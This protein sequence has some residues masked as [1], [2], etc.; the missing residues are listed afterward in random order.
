MI[1][2]AS[3]VVKELIRPAEESLLGKPSGISSFY[4]Q[5]Q[6]K[7]SN[8]NTDQNL[9]QST[10]NQILQK[11]IAEQQQ[12]FNRF[13]ETLQH[14]NPE[15]Y[16][17]NDSKII[18]TENGPQLYKRIISYKALKDI[19]N[20]YTIQAKSTYYTN[21]NKEYKPNIINAPRTFKFNID[22]SDI[23]N[24][25]FFALDINL[26]SEI[27]HKNL[28]LKK[29]IDTLIKEYNNIEKKQQL[30]I[31]EQK[32]DTNEY[33][34][35]NPTIKK[36]TEETLKNDQGQEQNK[37]YKMYGIGGGTVLLLI[38]GVYLVLPQEK[39]EKIQKID[40][41]INE[42]QQEKNNIDGMSPQGQ[43]LKQQE[44]QLKEQQQDIINSGQP[45][46]TTQAKE[47]INNQTPT[48]SQNQKETAANT[49]QQKAQELINNQ[50]PTDSQN[51]KKTP[52]NSNINQTQI[53]NPETKSSWMPSAKTTLITLGLGGVSYAGYKFWK[54][55]QNK[56]KKPQ[57]K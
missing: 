52:V 5:T 40:T 2:Q 10:E 44:Q 53:N 48:D 22:K 34:I 19:K 15:S 11:S 1:R 6:Y 9:T 56:N 47:L 38:G 12:D 31:E 3:R 14:E 7:F 55:R 20:Y 29:E 25:C 33:Q 26:A 49:E 21:N 30:N 28:P 13:T 16:I 32:Q 43:K 27:L 57:K 42:I 24:Y 17:V 37:K 41:Q 45:V 18:E 46:S 8:N 4:N 54:W 39:A 50:T 51:P 36:N 23:D 35:K